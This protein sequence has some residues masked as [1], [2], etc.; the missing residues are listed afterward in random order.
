MADTVNSTIRVGTSLTML[1]TV[2]AFLLF[3]ILL[4]SGLRGA[5]LFMLGMALGAVFLNYSYGFASGWR[6]FLL[7]GNG[8]PMAA[9]FILIGLCAL[10]FIPAQALGINAVLTQAPVSISLVLGAFIFGIGMQLANGC[11]SGVLFS[12]GGGSLRMVIALPFFILGSVLGSVW[13]PNALEW[14]SFDP[15][16]IAD[17]YHPSIRLLINLALIGGAVFLFAKSGLKLG[18]SWPAKLIKASVVIAILCWATF[19]LAGHAWGVTFGFTLWGAKI[20][21]A[22]GAP[23]QETVFWSW[24]GPANALSHSVLA[25]TSSVMNIGLLLGASAIAIYQLKFAKAG[26]PPLAQIGAA[27]SG[28]M[29]MG[30][31]ARLGFGCNIG[32]FVGGIASGSLHGWIWFIAALAGST[33]GIYFR[34]FSGFTDNRAE[35]WLKKVIA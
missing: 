9:H 11:G 8:L 16:L 34:S 17:G 15:I 6:Q 20:A 14:G 25:D 1:G 35:F 23:L 19:L 22:V 31:G 10:L 33:V 24:A 26:W 18:F 32:A 30:V 3:F 7:N 4:D 28:G 5:G 2:S 21:Q 12:F 27:A 13:L 29:L